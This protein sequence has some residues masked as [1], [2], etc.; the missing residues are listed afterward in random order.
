MPAM[1]G[2]EATSWELT[3]GSHVVARDTDVS[4]ILAAFRD[5]RLRQAEAEP[6]TGGSQG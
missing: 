5:L 3:L 2:A 6:G 1:A 4:F